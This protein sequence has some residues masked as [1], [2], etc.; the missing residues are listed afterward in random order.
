MS[1]AAG[2][3]FPSTG[4]PST[5][6]VK[7]QNDD[8]VPTSS[9]TS[10][11]NKNQQAHINDQQPPE[12]N[13]QLCRRKF[14]ARPMA[15]VIPIS[16]VRAS[17]VDTQKRLPYNPHRTYP[18]KLDSVTVVPTAN[19]TT[20]PIKSIPN[21]SISDLLKR[22][23]HKSG[24]VEIEGTYLGY[25]TWLPSTPKVD[26]PRSLFNPASLAYIGD[27]IY[28]LYARKHFLLPPLDIEEFNNR[29]MAVVRCEAQDAMLQKLISDD[30]LS[31]EE[32]DVLRWG[33]N[34]ASAKTRTKKRAGVAVYNR[35]SSLE[36]LMWPDLI[37]KAKEGGLDVIQ[38]YVFWN[39]HE[40]E[41]GKYYFEERYDLVKFIKLVQQAGLYVHL[42]IGPYACAEWNFGVIQIL[43]GNTISAGDRAGG[44]ERADD[45]GKVR[46]ISKGIETAPAVRHASPLTHGPN[47]PTITNMIGTAYGSLENPR[48]TF[49]QEVKLSYGISKIS[50]LSIAVGLPVGLKGE[51]LNLHSLS[52][53]STIEWVESSYVNER[54][55]LTWYKTYTAAS[56][57]TSTS[58][59]PLA[60]TRRHRRRPLI[61][62]VP[63]N[64]LRSFRPCC[65]S[66]LLVQADEGTLPL[67]YLDLHGRLLP[68]LHLSAAACRHAPPP[69]PPLDRTC[70]DQLF[71]EFPSVLLA[72]FDSPDGNEPLAIDMNTMSKG[73]V[74]INGQS[75]GRYW[76][77]YK[78]SGS[79]CGACNYSGVL[80]RHSSVLLPNVANKLNFLPN[81]YC[82]SGEYM[83][84]VGL[85]V[86]VLDGVDGRPLSASKKYL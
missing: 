55:P 79:N 13:V 58:R 14:P 1:S 21:I 62:P 9:S 84:E 23:I 64:F 57:L 65:S 51:A 56:F 48:I 19:S 16:A 71:E 86:D 5:G 41:P 45:K 34:I 82:E 6:C 52:G 74:W 47:S 35:A 50:L 17:S 31:K 15:A 72:T 30:F 2:T 39:G 28:E 59:P 8:I 27:C 4:F 46:P 29:V 3:I 42:R 25:E 85:D 81:E 63:I 83:I 69:S 32:R 40:P 12:G 73:Q 24:Q 76:N 7:Y 36:T 54:Q 61:G 49:S 22:D 60:A 66:G 67:A 77:Q 26:K 20:T 11:Y 78:A 68:H 80:V 44:R 10:R 33:K 43:T 53:S 38:T 70:S 18:K 37:Q 75:I